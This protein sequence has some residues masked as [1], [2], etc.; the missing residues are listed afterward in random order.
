MKAVG[1]VRVSTDKQAE[2]GV[3]LDAQAAKIRAMA[4]VHGAELVETIV[5]GVKS[6]GAR[7]FCG[8]TPRFSRQP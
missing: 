5:D 7:E 2:H 8:V 3:S 1:Y 4:V 6:P